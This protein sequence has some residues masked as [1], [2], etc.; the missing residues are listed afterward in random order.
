VDFQR[1]GLI[2]FWSFI[3][4]GEGD[5]RMDR[6]LPKKVMP[7]LVIDLPDDRIIFSIEGA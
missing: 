3:R 5:A 4:P 7:G 2:L 6:K 1:E